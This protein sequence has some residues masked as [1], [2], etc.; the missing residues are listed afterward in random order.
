MTDEPEDAV[1]YVYT[2]W[3]CPKCREANE[4]EGDAS[5]DVV[6]CTACGFTVRIREVR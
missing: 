5:S 1:G 4:V 2:H 6:A 3:D